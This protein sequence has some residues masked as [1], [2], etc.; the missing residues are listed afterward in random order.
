MSKPV[1]SFEWPNIPEEQWE[2]VTDET[3]R[4]DAFQSGA[5]RVIKKNDG[6]LA[7]AVG[8]RAMVVFDKNLQEAL[9]KEGNLHPDVLTKLII[10]QILNDLNVSM[11][12]L[13]RYHT[14]KA[15]E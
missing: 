1:L 2:K 14:T 5:V 9:R 8:V 13:L 7:V 6:D 3:M 11:V 4:Q 10:D 12:P 15:L